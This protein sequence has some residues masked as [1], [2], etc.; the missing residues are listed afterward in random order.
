MLAELLLGAVVL[1]GFFGVPLLNIPFWLGVCIFGVSVVAAAVLMFE[2]RAVAVG[3]KPF[4]EDPLGWRKAKQSYEGPTSD[5]NDS[6][7][8][9]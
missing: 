8:I 7:L 3:L 2:G 4:S 9:R 5:R 1:F 6:K